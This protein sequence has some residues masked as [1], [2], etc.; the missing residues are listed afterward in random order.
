VKICQNQAMLSQLFSRLTR[1]RKVLSV[2]P[3]IETPKNDRATQSPTVLALPHTA[4]VCSGIT[5]AVDNVTPAGKPIW[6]ETLGDSL[7]R[8]F[9]RNIPVLPQADLAVTNAE[10]DGLLTYREQLRAAPRKNL[11]SDI[12]TRSDH[13]LIS[14]VGSRLHPLIDA[15]HTAF[16]QHRPLILSPDDIWLVIAQGFSH[17]VT[18]NAETLRPRLVR[19]QGRRELCTD[20]SDLTVASFEQAIGS[21]SAQIR[22]AT[23]PVLHETL[24]CDFSTTTPAIR[25][26]SEVALMDTF[27]SY[28][29][30][31]VGCVCGIPKIT[32][33]GSPEDWRR[34]RARIEVLGTFELEW[35][36]SRLRPILD[37]FVLAA[38]GE[39]TADFWKA[40]YKPEKAYATTLTTGWI[41]DLFPYLNEAPHHKRNH[42]LAVAREGW[43]LPAR[44]GVPPKRFPS[45]LSSVPIKVVVK[46]ESFDLD[47][48]AGFLA[49]K[50]G[51]SDL[52]LS[53][54]IGW[55]VTEPPPKTPVVLR[56]W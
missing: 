15:V 13:D 17:H 48:V 54:V 22:D 26:A 56:G 50:Q 3:R 55:S 39:P 11:S 31:R 34:I 33:Q 42:V 47:L 30:Y 41:T 12:L 52:A 27:S 6:S 43:A 19:H 51:A 49:V 38:S 9:R 8:R 25:V 1:R 21:F 36:V 4:P 18:E 46:A 2:V 35:W 20:V 37:E 14:D 53:T 10:A 7:L 44:N 24:I 32:I 29:I 40:I 16:A 23:D 28:F 45:G 5:F